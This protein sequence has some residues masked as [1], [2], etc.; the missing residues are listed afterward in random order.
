MLDDL[1]AAGCVEIDDDFLVAPTTLGHV[2]SYYYIDYRTVRI[3]RDA[4]LRLEVPI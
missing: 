2:A 1:A 3:A 4:L